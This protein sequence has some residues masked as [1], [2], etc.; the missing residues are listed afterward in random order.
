M[1]HATRHHECPGCGKVCWG[2]GGY[3]SHKRACKDNAIFQIALIEDMVENH[4]DKSPLQG[5]RRED[6]LVRRESYYAK[7]G[8]ADSPATERES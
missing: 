3:S 6:A 4:Y 8:L 2:N 5:Y 7:L 1:T